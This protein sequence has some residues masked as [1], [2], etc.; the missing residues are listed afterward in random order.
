MY[1]VADEQRL[2]VGCIYIIKY[3][4][5]EKW[6]SHTHD[7]NINVEMIKPLERCLFCYLDQKYK[8]ESLFGMPE[9]R[10]LLYARRSINDLLV[11][12]SVAGVGS[13]TIN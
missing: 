1:P 11:Q 7:C 2:Y 3:S 12:S 4:A 5:N 13:E 8:V 9:H 10:I 6:H